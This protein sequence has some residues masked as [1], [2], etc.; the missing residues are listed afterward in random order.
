MIR[1][2]SYSALPDVTITVSVGVATFTD[3]NLAAYPQL[4]ELADAA[5]YQAKIRGK[6]QVATA[7]TIRPEESSPVNS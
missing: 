6:D 4:V 3:D 2:Q 5:M 7:G 1:G